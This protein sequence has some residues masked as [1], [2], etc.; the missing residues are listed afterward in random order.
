MRTQDGQFLGQPHHRRRPRD[1]Q[2]A[3]SVVSRLAAK[4]RCPTTVDA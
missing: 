4:E 3:R 2:G 1:L